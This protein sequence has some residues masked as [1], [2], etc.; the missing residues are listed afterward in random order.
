[1]ILIFVKTNELINKLH[2]FLFIESK[3]RD[4]CCD[5]VHQVE[6]V[7]IKTKAFGAKV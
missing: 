4:D 5:A 6:T 1:M 7:G 2:D 3:Q